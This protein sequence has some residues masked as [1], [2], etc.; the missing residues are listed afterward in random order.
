MSK[1]R[2]SI[3]LRSYAQNDPL[4]QYVKEAFITFQKMLFEVEKQFITALSHIRIQ[5]TVPIQITRA[6][7]PVKHVQRA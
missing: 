2:E 6:K 3:Y 5:P 4:Q 1:L 7:V